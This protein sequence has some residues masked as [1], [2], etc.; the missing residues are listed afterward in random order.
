MKAKMGIFCIFILVVSQASCMF[1]SNPIPEKPLTLSQK[2]QPSNS[3]RFHVTLCGSI[4]DTKTGFEWAPD[5]G[6]E[7]T[8][9]QAKEYAKNLTLCSH[10]DWKLPTL[11]QL[12]SLFDNTLMTPCVGGDCSKKVFGK[13]LWHVG[14]FGIDSTFQLG[15][16]QVWSK[17]MEYQK[18]CVNA[19][20]ADRPV[21]AT[22]DFWCAKDIEKMNKVSKFVFSP[23]ERESGWN[24]SMKFRVLAVRNPR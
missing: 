9:H 24:T 13:E 7:L 11:R 8:W 21:A 19:K 16:N 4:V 23:E 1:I 17:E 18:G 10:D 5:A 3:G 22:F 15:G 2:P 6:V 12:K 20:E 14:P